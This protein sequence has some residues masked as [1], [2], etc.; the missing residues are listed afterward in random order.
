MLTQEQIQEIKAR[1]EATTPGAWVDR[2]PRETTGFGHTVFSL[3]TCQHILS[4][5]GK[6]KQEK[7]AN[8]EFIAHAHQDIPA[9]LAH[10]EE[11]EARQSKP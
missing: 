9:L 6:N 4:M 11:L 2:E 10:I 1:H 5:H 7:L 3:R 8:A